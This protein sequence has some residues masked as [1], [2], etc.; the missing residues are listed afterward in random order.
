MD[1]SIPNEILSL[2]LFN[3]ETDELIVMMYTCRKMMGLV[4]GLN[5]KLVEKRKFIEN[6]ALKGYL[7][8][9]IWA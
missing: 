7:N 4:K 3:L 9:M 1:E 2:I 5:K 8:I 6:I